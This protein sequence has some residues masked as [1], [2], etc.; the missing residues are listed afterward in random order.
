M[1][2]ERRG[3]RWGRGCGGLIW[4]IPDISNC[5]LFVC[6]FLFPMNCMPRE[7]IEECATREDACR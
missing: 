4:D 5:L 3:G 7:F 6:F 1:G 2:K